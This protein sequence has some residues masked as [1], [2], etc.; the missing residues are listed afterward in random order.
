MHMEI[1]IIESSL[2]SN[3]TKLFPC[4]C[5]KIIL[6]VFLVSAADKKS[7]KTLGTRAPKH[8]QPLG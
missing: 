8:H 1:T 5:V 3:F 6:L 7:Q 4:I 2:L